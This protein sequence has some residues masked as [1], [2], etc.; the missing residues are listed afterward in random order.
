M[1]AR[2]GRREQLLDLAAKQLN[3][4][5]MSQR[6]LATLAASLGFT[7]NALYRYVED[8]EDLL[9]QVYRRSC[10]LLSER[11]SE[12]MAPTSPLLIVQR[13]VS[14]ALDGERPEIAA[15]NE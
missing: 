10:E 3:A 7:R 15:L 12:A 2:S 11:L 13:F 5:G 4:R 9:G 1:R 14:L 6:S 8:F